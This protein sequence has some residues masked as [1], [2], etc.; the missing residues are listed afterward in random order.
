MS[1]DIAIRVEQLSKCYQIYDKSHD[2]LKQIFVPR[3]QRLL[4][5]EPK[6][7]YHDFWAMRDVSFEVRKGETVG[8]I[9]KNG[10]GKSTLLQL[11]CGILNPTS[12]V[13]QTTG[14]IA[15]LLEL[16]SGFNPEFT[17][18]ENVYL[19]AAILGLSQAEIESRYDEIA[20]FA[21]I[22]EF[23]D[24]PVKT[25]SSG[26]YV[27]L[28]FAIQA[29]IDPDILVVDEA[30][31]VGDG[32]FVHRCM[33]RLHALQASGTTV[34]LV[35]HDG[36]FVKRFCD[37]AIWVDQGRVV[38]SGTSDSVVDE[39][40]GWLFR[41]PAVPKTDGPTPGSSVAV[42]KAMQATD[43][44]EHHIPN[45]DRRLGDQ[46]CSIVGVGLY[47]LGRKATEVVPSDSEVLLRYTVK[48]R[49]LRN[50]DHLIFGYI[51]RNF[52]GEE[53][54]ATNTLLEEYR[55]LSFKNDDDC[56]TVEVTITLPV[57]YPG[58]YSFSVG[59]SYQEGDSPEIVLADRLINAVV[60]AVTTKKSIATITCFDSRFAVTRTN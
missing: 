56:L 59:V 28:A 12:G 48:N 44:A 50:S 15:A 54:A 36:M 30:L 52:R 21:D 27:R 2:R 6:N 38:M 22:G 1:S 40:L 9:G 42:S 41:T 57:L 53:I 14:R 33:D 60:F 3:I 47:D 37:R 51:F 23:I 39:Y 18:R 11:I 32:Y 34:L 20:A 35:T 29:N 55:Q 7:Y 31:A 25:Y 24:Q 4:G 26:M 58:N 10:S 13:V 17:G 19:N 45:V 5:Q 16:G 8:I 49:A 43:D 46:R